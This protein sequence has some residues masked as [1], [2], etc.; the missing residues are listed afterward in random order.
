MYTKRPQKNNG[1]I[2]RTPYSLL[3]AAQKRR[4]NLVLQDVQPRRGGARAE[5]P[6]EMQPFKLGNSIKLF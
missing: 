4:K 6:P 2:Q 3:S 5:N 1:T